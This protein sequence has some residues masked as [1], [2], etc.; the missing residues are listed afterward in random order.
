MPSNS[1]PIANE[2]QQ[3][4]PQALPQPPLPG[5]SWSNYGLPG[6][7]GNNAPNNAN[8]TGSSNALVASP[9]NNI[10]QQSS[11]N[12]DQLRRSVEEQNSMIKEVMGSLKDLTTTLKEKKSDDSSS[13]GLNLQ[14]VLQ[15]MQ[16]SGEVKAE[17]SAIKTLLLATLVNKSTGAGTPSASV[18]GETHPDISQL[19]AALSSPEKQANTPNLLQQALSPSKAMSEEP[20]KPV[21]LT[22][23]EIDEKKRI[24]GIEKARAALGELVKQ[25]PT[26]NDELL[27]AGCGMMLMFLKNILKDPLNP[28]YRRVART[29]A[30]FKKSL[31][32][33][34]G[35]VQVFEA[36]GFD[37]RGTQLELKSEWVESLEKDTPEASG[38]AKAVI[39]DAI[40]NL[41]S[42]RE[43]R[44]PYAATPAPSSTA[45]SP[46]KPKVTR[47]EPPPPVSLRQDPIQNPVPPPPH[48]QSSPAPAAGPSYPLTLAEVAKMHAEGKRPEGI[49]DIPDKL[50]MD[51]P[52]K[53]TMTPPPKPWEKASV[54]S[55]SPHAE[56]TASRLYQLG[57]MG[58]SKVEIVELNDDGSENGNKST[59]SPVGSD[60]ERD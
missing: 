53:S 30:N 35:Y 6:L 60:Q 45:S 9:T 28:R 18:S 27:S 48:V 44:S 55:P 32:P 46:A 52:S 29:N 17:L 5:T 15:A 50:S 24:E 12:N 19:I 56:Q 3:N 51:E 43:Q 7:G 59:E 42:V 21:E 25:C 33:L 41:E 22:P 23:E 1:L 36:L 47:W 20:P 34:A 4:Q 13:N 40:T 39:E 2:Q 38:W 10:A 11:F 49:K 37:E 54:A 57:E 26:E 16:A 58:R 31:E 14:T 8:T